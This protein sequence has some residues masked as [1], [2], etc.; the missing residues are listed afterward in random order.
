M[1]ANTFVGQLLNPAAAV[2]GGPN[3]TN[4]FGGT[5]LGSV[6]GGMGGKVNNAGGIAGA[7]LSPWTA[8]GGAITNSF[9]DVKSNLPAP[10]PPPAI[11]T[12]ADTN[13]NAETTAQTAG[14]QSTQLAGTQGTSTTLATT[15]SAGRTLLGS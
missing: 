15:Y 2:T 9:Q 4:G 14:S 5:A 7:I 12:G 8:G 11:G 10:P 13:T 1:A 3:S 6:I